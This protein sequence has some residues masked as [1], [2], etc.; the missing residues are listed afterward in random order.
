MLSE[1]VVLPLWV[2]LLLFLA[3]VYTVMV[4]LVK[5]ALRWFL[6]RRHDATMERLDTT[7]SI[8]VKPFQQTNRYVLINRLADDPEL[9]A[10]VDSMAG[11]DA[12]LR[13]KLMRDIQEY[14]REIVP[15]FNAWVYYKVGYWLCRRISR[16]LY[17]VR[18]A[19]SDREML[20]AL[21]RD[22]TIVFVLNHRSNMDYV[23]TSYL[24]ADRVILSFAV[25]EWARVFPLQSI[26]R[27]M[28]AYFIRRGA[29]PPLYHRV[30][31]RYIQMATQA[32]VCQA[33]FPEGGLSRD[34][35]LA[36]PRIG[37]LDH[38]LRNYDYRTDRNIT[39]I[40][41]GIN[42]DRV[43]EDKN[44]VYGGRP[45]VKGHWYTLRR[46]MKFL[47]LNLFSGVR[48][49]W[50]RYGYAG[51]N[52]GAPFD[53]RSYCE[54]HQ[55]VFRDLPQ[56]DRIPAVMKLAGELMDS[57]G[58][59]IPVLPVAT[60]ATVFVEAGDGALR[61]GEILAAC[62]R[63]ITRLEAAGAPM[64]AEQKPRPRT[65]AVALENLCRRNILIK[66]GDYYSANRSEQALLQ[67]YANSIGHWVRDDS[68][69]TPSATP[70]ESIATD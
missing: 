15:S 66:D 8:K 49:R 3:A 69:V 38:M 64:R 31:G 32:G 63:L 54:Q 28:G 19:A 39:F 23:L 27:G 60:I 14:A 57:V 50:S 52:F 48:R 33:I 26:F 24:A 21:D 11:P 12:V 30:L 40:P 41:V 35:K 65:L 20:E 10:L 5:P 2:Y 37:L 55:L 68:R 4:S 67:Y 43:I 59:V 58:R 45:G 36:R 22:S 53:I 62:D 18:V 61:S 6:R 29:Q 25:G 47:R 56:R 70:L 46:V 16:L 34:G 44:L 7:L 9:L 42:Y 1:S 13:G 17:R 51:V